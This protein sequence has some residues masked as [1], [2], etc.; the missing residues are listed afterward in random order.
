MFEFFKAGRAR[1]SRGGTAS[2]ARRRSCRASWVRA[3]LLLIGALGGPAMA[4]HFDV[5]LRTDKGP[6]SGSR[7]Q[8][9]FF[10][11]LPLAGKLPFDAQS[12]YRIFPA[13]FGDFPG[14]KYATANP[15]F[16]AF[17]GTFVQGEEIHFRALGGLLYWSPA[18][19]KWGP[20]ASGVKITLYGGIPP[21]VVLG[22][23]SNPA[24]WADRYAYYQAGTRFETEGVSGPLT[25]LIDDV[26]AGGSFHSHLDWKIAAS[27]GKPP[28]GAYMLT[29]ELWSPTLDGVRPKYLASQPFHV[30]F[31]AGITAAQM[32]Q[33]FD[34]RISPPCAAQSLTWAVGAGSCS[35]LVAEVASGS[36]VVATDSVAPATGSASFSC[37]KG[38]WGA[39]ESTSCALP[40]P[41]ACASQSLNWSVGASSCAALVPVTASGQEVRLSD[42]LLPTL[43]EASF[44]CA[45]GVWG[46]PSHALCA[47]P[48]PAACTAQDL[49]WALA[50][51]TCSAAVPATASGA[52]AVAT[53][54]DVPATGNASFACSNGR[55]SAASAASCALPPPA[56]CAAQQMNWV[57]AGNSCSAFVA[58]TA[59]GGAATVTDALQP[60]TGSAS[61]ACSNGV[62]SAAGNASCKVP[63]PAACAAQTLSWKVGLETCQAAAPGAN[64]GALVQISAAN[65]PSTGAATF[66]CV[67]GLWSAP[68]EASCS[69][70][71]VRPPPP[72]RTPTSPWAPAVQ[73]PWERAQR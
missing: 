60:A 35:A 52:M 55:W 5:E 51:Q 34:A 67:D 57:Q 38:R 64:S 71:P 15:G 33:A 26:K 65:L 25:A 37:S 3:C 8:T 27:T 69:L 36:S 58:A 28:V 13:Y 10:G 46:Q 20:A 39:P 62:W 6:V 59:A 47:V 48:A 12:G 40:P 9:D 30:I 1:V 11:D 2:A 42:A 44:A 45:D 70:P 61:F 22:Y 21:E 53:D 17:G 41:A 56:A 50:G 4:Q 49:S 14:G 18:S 23:S 32:Q 73:M 66:A 29:L 72:A 24:L 43:G 19:G 16:Q 7:I 31:E 54:I 68:R 63:A